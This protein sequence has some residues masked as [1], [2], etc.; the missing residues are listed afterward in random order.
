MTTLTKQQNNHS[1]HFYKIN[2]PKQNAITSA[3]QKKTYLHSLLNPNEGTS[4]K[5]SLKPSSLMIRNN[6]LQ[7]TRNRNQIYI[8]GSKNGILAI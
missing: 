4:V 5:T 6:N 2:K 8:L 7:I 3:V 1:C